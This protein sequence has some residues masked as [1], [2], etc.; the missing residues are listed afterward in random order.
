MSVLIRVETLDQFRPTSET[1]PTRV[2]VSVITQ[3]LT[4]RPALLPLPMVRVESQLVEERAVTL[5]DSKTKSLR[6][7]CRSSSSLSC[8]F[9]RLAS[10]PSRACSSSS[11]TWRSRSWICCSISS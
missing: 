5:A 10:W 6:L 8:S 2:P 11:A 3:S 7:A 1:T 9:S 4:S